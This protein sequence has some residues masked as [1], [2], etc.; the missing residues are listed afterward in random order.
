MPVSSSQ[1]KC[2]PD[3]DKEALS[4]KASPRTDSP[5]ETVPESA[6][7]PL[8][9]LP[10][11]SITL[12]TLVGL[13]EGLFSGYILSLLATL[14]D[15]KV[16]S[17]K[18]NL[19][20]Y[21]TLVFVLR[22]FLGP[23]GDKYYWGKV[24]RRKSYILPSKLLAALVVFLLSFAMDK[25]IREANI[26]ALF[27]GLLFYGIAVIFESNSLNAFRIE[28]F[29]TSKASAASAA[30]NLSWLVGMMV[31]LQ[32]FT[33][34]N[35]D[36]VC[37]EYLKIE[38]G[39]FLSHNA[40]MRIIAIINI[41]S[42]GL[43]FLLKEK[44][45][46]KAKDMSISPLKIIRAVYR[47]KRL[48]KITLWN[49]FGPTLPFAM[50][51]IVNQY[52]INKGFRR[53]DY[54]LSSF[55]VVPAGI[56]CGALWIWLLKG[57]KYMTKV[58]A[59]VLVSALVEGLHIIAYG[60]FDETKTYTLTLI[61]VIIIQAIETHTDFFVPQYSM[62]LLAASK[63]YTVTYLSTLYSLFAL[64]QIP[65]TYLLSA[66]VD[67]VPLWALF[68]SAILV[69]L[70]GQAL[71]Y[72]LCRGVDQQKYDPL[73]E[74]IDEILDQINKKKNSQETPTAENEAQ[75]DQILTPKSPPKDPS[76]EQGDQ[77]L[78]QQA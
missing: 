31:S 11:L 26:A 55:V 8:K 71:T 38:G 36:H 12:F 66:L 3:P 76:D 51:I 64:F 37:R 40:F 77:E 19:L 15:L 47:H 65:F 7:S 45:V 30:K 54:I 27:F 49:L 18:R 23:L 74:E 22:M 17:E 69:H 42:L 75:N 34:F 78:A 73:G 57:Q 20:G 43:M 70:I 60:V 72:K 4:S 25:W 61:L 6:P 39:S 21:L 46:D 44:P 5:P 13:N 35:S 1:A 58:W 52:Y 2:I 14:T 62:Y 32:V 29:G 56:S 59:T 67:Y 9:S 53:E 24:G 41:C 16:P 10:W 28:F 50:K 33:A 63:K 48:R 68:G